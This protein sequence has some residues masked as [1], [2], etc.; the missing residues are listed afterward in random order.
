MKHIVS[1]QELHT[2]AQQ[3][4]DIPQV[5]DAHIVEFAGNTHIQS[6][7]T[8]GSLLIVTSNM[9]IITVGPEEA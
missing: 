3:L 2:F 5:I 6:D 9:E 7:L 8:D 4:N 1:E